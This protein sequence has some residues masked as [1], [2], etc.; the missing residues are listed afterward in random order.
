MLV[1]G[2]ALPRAFAQ[3][4]RDPFEAMSVQRSAAPTPAPEFV[5]RTTE[6]R[7]AR[8]AELRGKVVLLG[9]FSTA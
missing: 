7:E 5:F 4:P 2:T 6:G 9:F 8:L 1:L 3:A